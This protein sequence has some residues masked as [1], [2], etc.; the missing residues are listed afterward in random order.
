MTNKDSI[1]FAVFLLIAVGGWLQTLPHWADATTPG[2]LSGLLIIVGS[3]LAM[4]VGV[5][6]NGLVGSIVNKITGNGNQ[7]LP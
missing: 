5:N 3:S 7:K 2:A 6:T 4:A 1:K